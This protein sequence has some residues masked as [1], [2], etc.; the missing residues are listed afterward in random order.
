M[1]LCGPLLSPEARDRMDLFEF[2]CV[3]QETKVLQ[4]KNN[5]KQIAQ[6]P[7]PEITNCVWNKKT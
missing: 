6:I 1:A 2:L 3:G 4:H 5:Q 7:I